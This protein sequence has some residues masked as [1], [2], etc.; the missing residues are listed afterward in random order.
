MPKS[1]LTLSQISEC[2]LVLAPVAN[3]AAVACDVLN[4]AGLSAQQ[5]NDV[6]DLCERVKLGCGAVILSEDGMN[7]GNIEQIKNVLELQ[8]A[9]SDL[10][11]IL[12]T[13]NDIVRATEMFSQSGNIFLLE[14][15]FST[16]TFIR[17][18]EVALRARRRQ[19]EIRGLL[20]DLQYS[21]DDAE[22][23]SIAKSQFLANMSHEI[24]TPIGAIM[25]FIDLMKDTDNKPDENSR[26]MGI[27]ERNSQ[28]LLHLIDDI[29]DISKVEAG[30]MT[31]EKLNFKLTDLLADFSSVM[32]F[33]ASEK[34]IFFRMS[35]ESP[36]PESIISDP[37]RLRQILSNIVGNAI[38]FTEHG[39]VELQVCFDKDFLRFRV[40]D[41]GVGLTPDQAG[42]L[43]Q[44]FAQADAST[45][46]KF[47]GTGLGLV[48]SRRL[49]EALGGTLELVSSKPGVG[50]IFDIVIRP[51]FEK[52]INLVNQ[53]SLEHEEA[54]SQE[55]HNNQ[56]LNNLNILVVEDS[57]DNQVLIS[58]YLRETG[59][60]ISMASDGAQGMNVALN[61]NYDVILMD[62]QMPYMDGHQATREL[63]QRGYSKPIIALTAHAMSEERKKCLESGFSD[64]LTKPIHRA[65]LVE[66]LSQ[67]AQQK[68]HTKLKEATELSLH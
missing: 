5:C 45:N 19:Y 2:I 41:S 55:K 12:L 50:S 64:Y 36:I 51:G 62:I 37:V 21:K 6:E 11:I 8:E 20:A 68:R 65:T 9:W 42:R 29:L 31:I 26:F 7:E 35:F 49:A 16:L 48:L 32:G 56:I 30:K 53:Q 24:R 59:A 61:G 4:N 14:R 54:R 25:G 27:I 34:G 46:R 57:P 52:D 44:P 33:K 10:P 23:A 38:K 18:A 13:T 47:G 22:R 66:V 28:Q 43:F 58:T 63:R 15:P 60:G 1:K 3:D 67:V 17:S 40:K 39:A